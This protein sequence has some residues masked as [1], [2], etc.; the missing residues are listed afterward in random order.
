MRWKTINLA[1][2]VENFSV[3]AK[4][5]SSDTSAL[6]FCGVSNEDGIT[7][8]KYAAEDKAEDYKI[9]EKDCFAYNPYRIN[10]AVYAPCF[11][12]GAFYFS[13]TWYPSI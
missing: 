3:R 4:D 5:H 11:F 13:P 10:V 2:L 1:E 12:I 7:K 6:E 8:S 9:I